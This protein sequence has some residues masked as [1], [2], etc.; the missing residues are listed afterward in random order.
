[1]RKDLT[2]ITLVVDR[3]GSMSAIREDAEGG[4]NEFVRQ[5]VELDGEARVTLVEFDTEYQFVE[6]GTP[7]EQVGP[8]RLRP[9]GAT[10]L[11][12]AVGRAI[13]ETGARL[14]A[15]PQEDRPALVV[16][17]VTTDGCENSSCEYSLARVREM[18]SHQQSVY[19][20]KFSFLGADQDAF[21]EAG[22]MG[23]HRDG[24]ANFK[25]S[26]MKEAYGH[27]ANKVGR[28]RAAAALGQTIDNAYTPEEIFDM[29]QDQ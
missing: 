16:F 19:Q 28:M 24:I 22:A 26:K 6:R 4:I 10:A 23:V 21:A 20:W 9:R 5:Q 1:M 11:L 29:N 14:A 27:T 12:D 15:L 8:Y 3:S 2:D 25:K 18:I 17:V 7:A 13:D